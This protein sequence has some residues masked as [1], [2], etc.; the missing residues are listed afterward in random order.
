[1]ARYGRTSAPFFEWIYA[2]I[3]DSRRVTGDKGHPTIGD[4]RENGYG[5][6]TSEEDVL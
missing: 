2:Q 3:G 1:M 5:L 6:L 4:P